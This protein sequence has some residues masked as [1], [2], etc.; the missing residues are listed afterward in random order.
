MT[1]IGI[2]CRLLPHTMLTIKPKSLSM[3]KLYPYHATLLAIAICF[4]SSMAMAGI[5]TAIKTGAWE[6]GSN[7]STGVAPLATDNVIVP[8]GI[9]ITAGVVGDVCASLSVSALGAVY[10]TGTLSIGGSLANAGTFNSYAGSSVTFNGAAN[11]TISG[12]GSYS[13]AGTTG[14]NLGSSAI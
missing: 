5:N 7:W 3:L 11:S 4:H 14:M 6:T 8:A 10:V 13:I 2:P 12:G 1:K 9:S